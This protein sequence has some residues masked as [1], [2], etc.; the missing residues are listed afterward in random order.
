L[1]FYNFLFFFF[2]HHSIM[3][4]N[5]PPL[6]HFLSQSS[7]RR[8][9]APSI[10]AASCRAAPPTPN[11]PPRALHRVLTRALS[12]SAASA[13]PAPSSA[14]T[15][16][17][18]SYQNYPAAQLTRLPNGI[19]VV[20]E[21]SG[22]SDAA[23]VGVFIDSGSR[24]ERAANNGVAHFLEHLIFKGTP[25]RTQY[26]LETEV[27]NLGAHLNAYTS[28]EQT[29]Y[30]AKCMRGDLPQSL[31]LLSDIL[32]N[33][34]L[35]AGAIER[36]RPVILREAEEVA[37]INDEV[38]FDNLHMAAF[39]DH[40]LGFTILGPDANIRSLTRAQLLE[41]ISTHYI[42]PRL[43]VVAAGA[44]THAQVVALS[45]ELFSR[46]PASA[47][48]LAASSSS[49]EDG[50]TRPTFEAREARQHVAD[51]PRVDGESFAIAFEAPSQAHADAV[52]LMVLHALIGSWDGASAA[53]AESH[54]ALVR[55]VSSALVARSFT[56][57]H[58]A[59]ADTGLFGVH[60]S[61]AVGDSA[62]V[63][64]A[65][66]E[67]LGRLA[68]DGYLTADVLE[69]AKTQ[70]KVNLMA[71]LDSA[72]MICEDI[73]R[74]VLCYGRRVHPMEMAMRVEAVDV[75]AVVN[76]VR[77]YVRGKRPALSAY[78]RLEKFPNEQEVA[79]LMAPAIVL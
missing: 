66:G 78:G 28:R 46:V 12:T 10:A 59:Y 38:V 30:Y 3:S 41:Y 76:C 23:A 15:S 73:G 34:L 64:K 50:R 57:F 31:E 18:A 67:E 11:T 72:A 13:S 27:E 65:V 47:P 25:K 26:R 35:E 62:R 9:V 55:H 21:A 45:R 48:L 51:D 77:R 49:N 43:V 24:F 6:S 75:A 54:S 14:S 79:R 37:K 5:F 36:E 4:F 1:R 61:C 7:A 58:S 39:P 68:T 33:S 40:G 22:S 63:L 16:Q 53:G 17:A 74:Q 8:V 42:G 20:T 44:V 2:A 19:R 29:F 70:V 71:P 52:P 32:Q 69:L 56:A 60:A